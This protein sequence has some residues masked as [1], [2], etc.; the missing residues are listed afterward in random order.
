[1]HTQSTDTAPD[2]L[3]VAPYGEAK[4]RHL[5]SIQGIRD[6][7]I[8][9]ARNGRRRKGYSLPELL[10]GAAVIAAFLVRVYQ[11][12][13]ATNA[14][15]K[16]ADFTQEVGLLNGTIHETYINSP[17]Y[18]GIDPAGISFVGNLPRKYLTSDGKSV[19]TSYKQPVTFASATTVNADDSFTMTTKIPASEC[20]KTAFG[21][22]GRNLM[23]IS[24][25]GTAVS[26]QDKTTGAAATGVQASLTALCSAATGQTFMPVIW[27]FN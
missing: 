26:F 25:G 16:Y 7:F 17:D 22:M 23:S 19:T 13:S 27:T 3:M 14:A 1:M 21:D 8:K 24:I 4:K 5:L 15:D 11:S 2:A 20:I 9:P 18:S 6:T 12:Y 10:L